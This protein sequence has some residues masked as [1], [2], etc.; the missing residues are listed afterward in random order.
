MC[1]LV[2]RYEGEGQSALDYEPNI[3]RVSLPY[4]SPSS[5]L[6]TTTA[7]GDLGAQ[8]SSY[9]SKDSS[10]TCVRY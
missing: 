7:T 9:T 4:S 6:V 8:K 1:T 2:V 5:E 10:H 3:F